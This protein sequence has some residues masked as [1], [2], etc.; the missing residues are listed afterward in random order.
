MERN[1]NNR[2]G[3][4][5]EHTGLRTALSACVV[6]MSIAHWA[7]ADETK[8]VDFHAQI[9]P[10]LDAHCME[11]HNRDAHKGGLGLGS[12]DEALKGGDSG[13]AAYRPGNS[14]ESA[15][16]QRVTSTDPGFRMPAKGDPLSAEEI[17]LLKKWIDE[18]ASWG[19]E[20][21]GK[22]VAP[23][24]ADFWSFQKPVQAPLPAVKKTDWPRNPIDTFTLA[25]M[26]EHGLSP[27]QE[28]DAY[29]LI[30]RV[31]LDLT[32]LPPAPEEIESFVKDPSRSAYERLVD[33]LLA[34][35]HYGEAQA[36]RWMDAAR[37]AD[38]NGY[39]K[40]RPR[41]AWMYRDWAIDAFNRNLPYDRFV[42]EQL[43]GDLLPDAGVHDRIATGF[44]R[45]TMVNEEGGIDVEEFRYE[46]MVD[47]TNTTGQVFLGLTLACAQCH[48]HKY[49]PIAHDEYYRFYAFLNNTDDVQIEVP[50][51]AVAK[52]RAEVQSQIDALV[53]DLPNKFPVAA[54]QTETVSLI[55]TAVS[56]SGGATLAA[57]GDGVITVSG[58]APDTDSYRVELQA[59]GGPITAI[60]IETA[61]NAGDAGAGRSDKSNF[62]L[63]EVWATLKSGE[64]EGRPIAFARAESDVTYAGFEADK[65]I[66]TSTGT[67]WA[68]DAPGVDKTASHWVT[69]HL[70]EP[71]TLDGPGTIVLSLNQQYGRAH[72]LARFKVSVVR[73]FYPPSDEPDNVRRAKYFNER[74]AA[75]DAETSAKAREWTV[76][77]PVRCESK[78]HVSFKFLDDGSILAHGDNPNT[79]TYNV[80]FRTDLQN[81]TAIRIET[82]TDPSLPGDGPGR[83]EIMS[84]PGD[85]LLSEVKASAAPWVTPDAFTDAALKNPTADFAAGGRAPELTLDGKLDSGWGINGGQ[86]KPHAIVY[87]LASPLSNDGGTLLKLIIDQYFVHY[88]TIGRFRVSATSGP[89]PVQASG[90]PAEIETVLAKSERAPDEVESL[91]RYYL[92]VAPELAEP[93]KQIADLRKSMPKFPT[94]QVLQEREA[95]RVTRVFHRGEFLNP[96]DPVT[97]GVPAVL[98]PLQ[99]GVPMNRLTLARWIA[100]EENPLTARVFVNRLWQTYFGRGIVASVEDFGARGDMPTHPELLDWLA[101][102]FMRRNWDI[103]DLTRMIVTSATY[104]QSSKVTPELL[105]ADPANEWLARAPR[106]RVEAEFVR[107]IAL[108]ASGLLSDRIGGPSMKPPLPEGALSL[109]YPGEG[110]TVADGDDRY[111]RGMYVYWKRTLPYPAASTFDAPARDVAV[112]KRNRS[113][114]PLQAL[115]LLNDP[116]FVEAAQAFAK[117]VLAYSV[118]DAR[119]IRY[120]FMLCVS[121][122]P[123][124]AEMKSI[125]SFLSAQRTKLAGAPADTSIVLAS[126]TPDRSD[127]AE[128]AAWVLVCRSLLNLDETITKG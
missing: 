126:D 41:Q 92:T 13:V 95:P 74:F 6:L 46:A 76:L 32:G 58:A 52:R 3:C 106:Y 66:D 125:E 10:I 107:D 14:D 16:I 40:D 24:G 81:I 114:T 50:D 117:R 90:V 119:R 72:T 2:A 59:E 47:R 35:P 78:Y 34:S 26:E 61:P 80:E 1:G 68:V 30:R 65:A 17:A 89:L 122:P 43:A 87:E 63:S 60:R 93:H 113:N 53:A 79:D 54:V 62:V 108:A 39:E 5:A 99:S 7:S 25:K 57:D 73:Q 103:K 21:T 20:S 82:L 36:M 124:E 12:A 96:K 118:D 23:V 11:C 19:G 128:L 109:V 75:W 18:G 83:G 127:D 70:K 104:R 4:A 27:S 111:R 100:S 98:P 51:E 105:A 15:I 123:D 97:A 38:T 85:F 91:K 116:V 55:P 115:T 56:S 9:L 22:V 33:R 101:V 94:A 44:H 8:K 121:R 102:E 67:G 42:I 28:A 71:I 110:W 112:V 69:L 45:N 86:G 77:E 29:T 64:G 84:T 120:A 88:H 37:Y 48:S 31:S 49:D